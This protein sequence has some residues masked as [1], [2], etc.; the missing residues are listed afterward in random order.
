MNHRNNFLLILTGALA[1]GACV[2]TE[3]IPETPE[4][5]LRVEPASV[6]LS[7]GNTYQLSGVYTDEKGEDQSDL[8]QWATTAPAVATVNAGGLVTAGTAGQ[9]WVVATAPGGLADSALVTVIQNDNSVAKVVITSATN[10]LVVGATLQLTARAYNASNQEIPGQNATWTSSNP[11]V[12]SVN[13]NGLVTAQIAGQA[14]VTASVAGVSSLP[15]PIQVIPASGLSRSGTFSGNMGYS[16]SGTATLQ[17]N[18]SALR[19]IFGSN[20]QAS[21]GP[22]LGVYLAKNP[23]G[24]LNA[25]NSVKIA[26][27]AQNSGMQTYDVPAGVGLNEYD[28]VV[29][30]CIPFTVR[31]GTAKLM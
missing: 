4:P 29:V 26:N 3:I 21:S 24:A 5:T 1:F 20:F 27:L 19:L 16:V 25:Q 6:S 9:T 13:S 7:V 17:Q 28:Y 11:N 8:I 30:Y 18:G 31:F 23:S 22:Q 12:L 14:S 15:L 2:K 10:T